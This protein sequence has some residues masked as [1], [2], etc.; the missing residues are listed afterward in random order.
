MNIHI[1][2]SDRKT[3]SIQITRDLQVIVRAPRQ[4]GR[5]EIEHLVE[6]KRGW[7]ES[8]MEKVRGGA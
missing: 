5:G 2:R 6:E 1:I 8:H 3:I 7:I 4:L